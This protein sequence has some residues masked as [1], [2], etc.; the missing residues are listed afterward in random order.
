VSLRPA[1]EAASW[2]G[3]LNLRGDVGDATRSKTRKMDPL[4]ASL[5][6]VPSGLWNIGETGKI[7]LW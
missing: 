1:N 7:W 6:G 4:A 3:R 2:N 5:T